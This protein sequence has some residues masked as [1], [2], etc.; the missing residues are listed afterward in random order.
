ME[1]STTWL[2][3]H[4]P[5]SFTFPLISHLS[6]THLLALKVNGSVYFDLGVMEGTWG[7]M[8]MRGEE[9]ERDGVA[10]E[11]GQWEEW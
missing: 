7:G 6:Y 4:F 2:S 11:V 3:A 5:R 10:S 8:V 9:D 1:G